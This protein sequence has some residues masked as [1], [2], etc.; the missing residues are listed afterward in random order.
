VKT[1]ETHRA[2]LMEKLDLHTAAALTAIA[3]E[4]GLVER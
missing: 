2:N 1:V 4:K 3:I